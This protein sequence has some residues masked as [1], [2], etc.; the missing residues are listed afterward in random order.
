VTGGLGKRLCGRRR[1]TLHILALTRVMI[2]SLGPFC[3]LRCVCDWLT[4]LRIV[5]VLPI[6]KHNKHDRLSPRL[7]DK[8]V[9]QVQHELGMAAG[10]GED[11]DQVSVSDVGHA[12][13]I[14][15]AVSLFG[16]KVVN[17]LVHPLSCRSVVSLEASND[18]LRLR[19]VSHAAEVDIG[20][21]FVNSSANSEILGE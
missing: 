21:L 3:K 6:H 14:E 10:P 9:L 8:V 15:H 4:L 20:L 1:R 7:G 11:R 19:A 18:N 2:Q 16:N 13:P 5:H 17:Q 12:L